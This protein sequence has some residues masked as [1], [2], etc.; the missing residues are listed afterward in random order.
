MPES[1]AIIGPVAVLRAVAR[2]IAG[3]PAPISRMARGVV[4]IAIA[5]VIEAARVPVRFAAGEG[6]VLIDTGWLAGPFRLASALKHGGTIAMLPLVRWLLRG[7][8]R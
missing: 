6:G 2:G 4:P 8:G 7:D 5:A 3:V 1:I